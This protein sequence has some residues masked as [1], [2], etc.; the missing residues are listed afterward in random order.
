MQ[1]K[2]TRDVLY[3][4]LQALQGL[5]DRGELMPIL[6]HVLLEARDATLKV[7]AT[8]LQ[9]SMQNIVKDVEVLQEGAT[10][11]PCRRLFQFIRE[12]PEG[13][14][15]LRLHGEQG[16]SLA[17]SCGDATLNLR[18]L[19]PEQFPSFPTVP[20]DSFVSVASTAL[21]EMID[22]V[23]YAASSEQIQSNLS[24]IHVER[25]EETGK[26]RFVATDGHRLSLV[27]REVDLVVPTDPAPIV[28][29]KG[30]LE[31]RRMLGHGHNVS[32]GFHEAHMGVKLGDSSVYIRLVDALFPAYRDVIPRFG[33]NRARLRREA[34][35]S[36]IRKAS[37]LSTPTCL[38]SVEMEFGKSRLTV[39]SRNPEVGEIVEFVDADYSGSPVSVLFNPKYISDVLTALDSETVVVELNDNSSPAVIKDPGDEDFLAVIMPMR[40]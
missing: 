29:K 9:V 2:I 11:V 33:A 3:P 24:G 26:L 20:A 5:S 19:E 7:S 35:L 25:I 32:I 36:A 37:I 12:L 18:T 40:L 39:S 1:V 16:S 13:A 21:A 6:S 38:P 23:I 15:Q 17:V 14:I 30:I 34:L 28:P 22:K 27:D 8:N 4:T 10:T 31:L